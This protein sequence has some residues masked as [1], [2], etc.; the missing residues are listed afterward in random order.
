MDESLN[1]SARTTMDNVASPRNTD[2]VRETSESTVRRTATSVISNR[3]DELKL[4]SLLESTLSKVSTMDDDA[5]PGRRSGRPPQPL[6]SG[7]FHCK[8]SILGV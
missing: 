1:G 8:V 7:V 6:G 5:E 3:Q 2:F 4:M